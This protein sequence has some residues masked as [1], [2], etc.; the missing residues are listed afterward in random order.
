MWTQIRFYLADLAHP[1][2]R[3]VVRWSSPP[4]IDALKYRLKWPIQHPK[5]ITSHWYATLTKA[6]GCILTT[7][8]GDRMMLS[9]NESEGNNVGRRPSFHVGSRECH[10]KLIFTKAKHKM[11]RILVLENFR[12][13]QNIKFETPLVCVKK[14]RISI[15]DFEPLW[16]TNLQ[17]K[18][19]VMFGIYY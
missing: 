2:T 9:M 3:G 14:G 19:V 18:S 7:P 6:F 11:G 1:N 4:D 8:K 16:N 15:F 13:H 10:N 12:G 17:Q 5:K